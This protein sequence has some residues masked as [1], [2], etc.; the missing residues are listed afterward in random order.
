MYVYVLFIHIWKWGRL[1]QG[2]IKCVWW[3]LYQGC[4][5]PGCHIAMGPNF[6]W[7]CLIKVDPSYGTC[8]M[9]QRV[10]RWILDF[11]KISAP[12]LYVVLVPWILR[13]VS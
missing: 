1:T 4:T 3:L 5:N 11:W 8:F 13:P 10:L 9:S 12:Q 2:H 6:V 7:Y